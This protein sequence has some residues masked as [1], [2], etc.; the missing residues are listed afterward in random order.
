MGL[1]LTKRQG[2]KG[3]VFSQ[4]YLIVVVKLVILSGGIAEGEPNRVLPGDRCK[5]ICEIL[6]RKLGETFCD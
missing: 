5:G 4:R 2:P 3:T 6:P 1:F